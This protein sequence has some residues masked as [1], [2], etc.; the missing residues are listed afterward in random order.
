MRLENFVFFKTSREFGI[1]DLVRVSWF[2]LLGLM[3]DFWI[4]RAV[5]GSFCR[6]GDAFEGS[7]LTAVALAD[8]RLRLSILMPSS[9]SSLDTLLTS[10]ILFEDC[11]QYVYN[12]FLN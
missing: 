3:R 10:W 6:A 9:S 7:L 8:A 12:W 2:S 1:V 4:L 5:L 11:V